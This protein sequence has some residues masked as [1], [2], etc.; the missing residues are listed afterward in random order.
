MGAYIYFWDNFHFIH[1]SGSPDESRLENIRQRY[2]LLCESHFLVSHVFS[3]YRR[4]KLKL[5]LFKMLCAYK[6]V[7][8]NRR[9]VLASTSE[10]RK[11][12]LGGLVRIYL[13]QLILCHI[14]SIIATT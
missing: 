11:E 2:L 7:L 14:H 9:I 12:I 10:R 5:S 4:I 3:C 1:V 6:T 13:K 8:A